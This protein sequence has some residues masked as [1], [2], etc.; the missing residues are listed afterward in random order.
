MKEQKLIN[1]L[2]QKF[3]KTSSGLSVGIGDDCA[4]IEGEDFDL[5]FTT[6]ALLEGVHFDLEYTPPLLLGRK[7]LSVNLSDIAA[8]GGKPHFYTVNLGVP[9]DFP[10][11]KLKSIYKGMMQVGK[12]ADVVLVGGDTCRSRSGLVMS[13]ALL[14]K[15][16]KGRALLRKGASP[17]DHI[18]VTGTLGNAGLGLKCLK[19][20]VKGDDAK[21]FE[22]HFNDPKARIEI[23]RWLVSTG[24]VTSMIDISD[25]L[26]SDL[27]HIADQSG[28]GFK[29]SALQVPRLQGFDDLCR[30]LGLNPLEM[31][32]TSGEDYELAFTVA[33]DKRQDFEKSFNGKKND[34]PITLLGEIT[35]DPGGRI[36]LGDDNKPLSF[37]HKGFD[38]FNP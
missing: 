26:L 22:D 3:P 1:F 4:V 5:L 30:E 32:L 6:D 35:A 29:I 16:P 11:E 25:G 2:T 13:V 37:K 28:V 15:V 17:G 20:K 23:G 10:P 9:K 24:A 8:M 38:H 7:V 33:E 34:C 12:A 18:Y 27:G 36:V 21:L 19:E 31:I 14:G